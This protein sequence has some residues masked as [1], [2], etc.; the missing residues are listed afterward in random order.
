[1]SS[2]LREL[3]EDSLVPIEDQLVGGFVCSDHTT[4]FG[5]KLKF[6]GLKLAITKNAWLLLSIL[7][8][9]FVVERAANSV[10]YKFLYF[11]TVLSGRSPS[12]LL[13][14]L[15]AAAAPASAA[16]LIFAL[17]SSEWF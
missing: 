14:C 12:S 5:Q 17:V 7:H 3:I 8:S 11:L 6:S 16:Y 4:I 15:L 10:V 9:P 1:M 13:K 2:C